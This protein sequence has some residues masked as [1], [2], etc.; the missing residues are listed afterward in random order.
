M[1][2]VENWSRV[3][4]PGSRVVQVSG[5]CVVSTKPAVSVESA[6]IEIAGFIDG[7]FTAYLKRYLKISEE[8]IDSLNW[9]SMTHGHNTCVP[10]VAQWRIF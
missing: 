3:Q 2:Y 9:T 10:A 5:I 1:G 4:G 8:I 7:L 6:R